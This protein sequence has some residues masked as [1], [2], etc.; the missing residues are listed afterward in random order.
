[1][2][3][4]VFQTFIRNELGFIKDEAREAGVMVSKYDDIGNNDITLFIEE[5]YN[6]FTVQIRKGSKQ[7]N[8]QDY[9]RS[10]GYK[11]FRVGNTLALYI[12]ETNFFYVTLDK[13]AL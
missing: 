7:F 12:N 10:L 13:E 4:S 3:N 6:A 5:N 9:I 11:V 1:M 8:M 2:T